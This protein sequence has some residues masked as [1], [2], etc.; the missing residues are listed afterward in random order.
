MP[1]ILNPSPTACK[2][3]LEIAVQDYLANNVVLQ[4]PNY[5]WQTAL[6]KVGYRSR[7]IQSHSARLWKKVENQIKEFK[8]KV[9]VRTIKKL[10]LTVDWVQN[11]HLEYMDKA[12]KTNDLPIA[13]A[14]LC[15]LGDTIGAYKQGVFD[16][17]D[18]MAEIT[19]ESKRIAAAIPDSYFLESPKSPELPA[20]PVNSD[21]LL[22]PSPLETVED[23]TTDGAIGKPVNSASQDAS[24]LTGTSEPD[25][26]VPPEQAKSAQ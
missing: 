1:Q 22:Q 6:R 17:G 10:N 23:Y 19:E 11:K 25:V 2:D 18:A 4:N 24:G 12:E 15:K 21:S 5:L 3:R 7:Y 26:I 14:N 8:A 16:A 9:T 13:T 20:S